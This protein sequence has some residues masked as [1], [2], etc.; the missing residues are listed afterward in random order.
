MEDPSLDDPAAPLYGGNEDNWVDDT[1]MMTEEEMEEFLENVAPV[2][3]TLTKLRTIAVKIK[4]S[5]TVLMPT[6]NRLLAQLALKARVIPI[7][8]RTRWN[9]TL[10]LVHAAVELRMPIT[11]F[12]AS[13]EGSDALGAFALTPREWLIAEQLIDALK[14][15]E[16]TDSVETYPIAMVLHPAYKLEYFETLKWEPAWIETA[17][18]LVRN[19][20]DVSYSGNSEDDNNNPVEEL[21][22]AKP[23]RHYSS[24]SL[25][26][27]AHTRR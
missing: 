16:L 12:C 25:L 27:V 21:P 26:S 5:P 15:Y 14:Y 10:T 20:F 2:W 23:V 6:W 4:A 19:E 9:S 8:V 1:G 13:D 17:K 22:K 11:V 24:F 18:E 7:D 3:E